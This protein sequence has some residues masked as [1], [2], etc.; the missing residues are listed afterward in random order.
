M[1]TIIGI[2]LP[3]NFPVLFLLKII[4]IIKKELC[5]RLRALDNEWKQN[6]MPN[7]FLAHNGTMCSVR[8]RSGRRSSIMQQVFFVWLCEIARL[9][10]YG[11]LLTVFYVSFH[12]FI[13]RKSALASNHHRALSSLLVFE[14]LWK[15][16]R[17]II[18]M[19]FV[20]ISNFDDRTK[21]TISILIT[22]CSLLNFELAV[23]T[24]RSIYVEFTLSSLSGSP[25]APNRIEK[26]L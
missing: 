24:I 4:I 5:N 18:L 16:E 9:W 7:A 26:K 3:Q 22:N 1:I 2:E 17:E 20:I 25:H 15:T 6:W 13:A 23:R 8:T 21:K 10:I 14:F 11:L 12:P 19:S